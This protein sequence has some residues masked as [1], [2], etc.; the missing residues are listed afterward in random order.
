VFA[1]IVIALVAVWNY[2]ACAM[3]IECRDACSNIV[4]PD[5]LSSTYSKIAY[6]GAGKIGVIVTDISIIVTLLG[7]CIAYQ[8]TFAQLL[9]QI[10]WANYS[11]G[12][13]TAFFGIVALPLCC[14]PNVG[15]LGVFSVFGLVC[16][17]AS[18]IVILSYGVQSYSLDLANEKFGTGFSDARSAIPLWPESMSS[19]S[20]FIGVATFCFGLCTMA[21]PVEESMKNKNKFSTAVAW[22]LVFVWFMYVLLGDAG[23]ILYVHSAAGIRDNILSN[24]PLNSGV[25]LIVR[26][27]MTT[28]CKTAPVDS[29]YVCVKSF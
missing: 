1:P 28:V 3:M 16:L 22:S 19:V 10:P 15:V 23:A 17:V 6:A 14:A 13:L 29:G 4:F 9:Q 5:H 12:T 2:L 27:A 26:L 21:F 25:S 11:T 18:V 20:S 24:L 7:V 8:I